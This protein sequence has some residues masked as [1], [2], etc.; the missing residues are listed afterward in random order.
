MTN[1]T[2]ARLLLPALTALLVSCGGGVP[3]IE[4]GTRDASAL[5][6][7]KNGPIIICANTGS[8][9]Q[10]YRIDSN[11]RHLKQITHMPATTFD[12]WIPLVSRDGKR[13]AF[14]YGTALSYGFRTDVYIINVD[15]SGLK[16][17]THDG[18]SSSPAWSPDGLRLIYSTVSLK[19]QRR[20]YLVSV[21]LGNPE[22]RT[23]LTDDLLNNYYGEYA[24][25][26]K[27]IVYN[28]ADGGV[29][30][31]AWIMN[32]DGS[33]KR[34]LSPADPAF[35]PLMVSNDSQRTLVINHCEF[36][37]PL[38]RWI[39]VMNL[40][41]GR[42]SEITNPPRGL[43]YD[44]YPAWSPDEREIAFT[45]NR[46]TPNNVDLFVMNAD[47]TNIHRIASGLTVGGCSDNNCITPSWATK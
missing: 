11:G 44:L 45:S 42:V 26:G 13:I 31:A 36:P 25:D 21:P 7:R 23:R 41:D 24:P 40:D 8:G 14:T 38:R 15:G 22:H 4:L 37:F 28:T 32:A 19:T 2:F 12:A 17:L 6:A 46:L 20:L 5:A 9:W 18:V 16:R 29:V 10:I 35:C 30:S 47:G 3:P 43:F 33:Q 34:S 27:H 39:G 1:A